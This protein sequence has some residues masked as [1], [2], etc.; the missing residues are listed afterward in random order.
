MT[1]KVD[2]NE[3]NFTDLQWYVL[4]F[5]TNKFEWGHNDCNTFIVEYVD[6]IKG[7]EIIKEVRG[8][9]W[10]ARSAFKFTRDYKKLDAGLEEQGFTQAEELQDGDIVTY[11]KN[12]FVCGHIYA[13]SRMHSMDTDNGYM[14]VPVDRVN[15]ND[16]KLKIWRYNVGS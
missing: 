10:D 11:E 1:E 13:Y 2:V 16:P 14:S 3:M 7:T 5:T 9:Y 15:M 4:R 8:K 6:W 12:G